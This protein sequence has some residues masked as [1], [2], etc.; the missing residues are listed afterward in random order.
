L[1]T[2]H[3]ELRAEALSVT[4]TPQFGNPSNNVSNADFGH[5]TGASGGATG[6]RTTELAAKVTF[7]AQPPHLLH[8]LEGVHRFES[9]L[10][11][12]N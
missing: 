7:E 4:N 3:L 12:S 5:I 9:E 6:N 8:I 11:M 2:R 1:G 10:E